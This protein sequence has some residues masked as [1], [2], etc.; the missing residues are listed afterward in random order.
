MTDPKIVHMMNKSREEVA[1]I[2]VEY[3]EMNDLLQQRIKALEAELVLAQRTKWDG[4][5][6]Q[7]G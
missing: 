7:E 4:K 1:R 3:F 5:L 2:A 6:A